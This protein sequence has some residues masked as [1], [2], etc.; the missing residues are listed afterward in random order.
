M[1]RTLLTTTIIVSGFA[2]TGEALA[3]RIPGSAR[4]FGDWTVD[5]RANPQ[6]GQFTGCMATAR[7]T[8][9]HTVI[10]YARTDDFSM[11][12]QHPGWRMPVGTD[13][14]LHAWIDG[15]PFGSG[16]ARAIAYDQI[17][18]QLN[19][20]VETFQALRFGNVLSFRPGNLN[21]RLTGTANALAGVAYCW[22]HYS[23]Y[24]SN[25]FNQT[26]NP[27]TNTGKGSI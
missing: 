7:Y 17:L 24:S 26:T 9:G 4:Q 10:F 19:A 13:Y 14:Q 25:P 22:G 11:S 2:A 1:F 6:T 16:P 5:A 18:M 21:F 12:I 15:R 27:G 20:T 3:D 8:T 23:G